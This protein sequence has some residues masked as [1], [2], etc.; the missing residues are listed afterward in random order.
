MLGIFAEDP[1]DFE[2]L[3]TIVRKLKKEPG[4]KV[5]GKG[6]R[7]CGNLLNSCAREI[8]ALYSQGFRKFIICHDADGRN[9]E[10]I[11]QVVQKRVIKPSELGFDSCILI[12]VQEI[13]AWI[14]A[15]LSAARNLFKGWNPRELSNP[16]AIPKPKEKLETLSR[17]GL[18]RPRY[19]HGIH[20]PRIAEHLDYER[21]KARCPSFRPLVE[22]L[23]A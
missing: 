14:L 22:F 10:E 7:G 6:F 13:E 19:I 2:T 11:R 8:R 17:E 23:N 5:G 20:N 9:P 18:S 16:E 15:D 4:L 3:R 21:V 1:S 12:P